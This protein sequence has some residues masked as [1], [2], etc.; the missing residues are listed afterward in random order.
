MWCKRL[1]IIIAP[2]RRDDD[3]Q[4]FTSFLVFAL[5]EDLNKGNPDPDF[6]DQVVTL[7]L[8]VQTGQ[9][10]CWPIRTPEPFA[11]VSLLF[12][13]SG[14]T[15]PAAAHSFLQ[16]SQVTTSERTTLLVRRVDLNFRNGLDHDISYSFPLE[17]IF[18]AFC[19]NRSHNQ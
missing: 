11:G 5:L 16:A 3:S 2:F 8:G 1:R 10:R 15:W 6:S 12:V 13:Y 19:D 4:P 14:G 9:N 18:H 7:P 17:Q